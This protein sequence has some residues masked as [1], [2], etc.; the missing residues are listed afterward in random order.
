MTRD[1]RIFVVGLVAALLVAVVVA[2][3]AS[4]DPD[5]LEYVAEQEGFL[6]TAEDHA[7]AG[8]PLAD[9]GENVSDNSWLNTALAGTVGVLLTLAIGYG[10]FWVARRTNGN[11]PESS[12]P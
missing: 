8:A 12:I 6:E 5:G 7:L 4:S 1:R 10:F 9:Y 2:Q 11:R 3:F